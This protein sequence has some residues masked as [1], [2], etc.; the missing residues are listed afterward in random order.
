MMMYGAI[1]STVKEVILSRGDFDGV[2]PVGT[3]IQNLRTSVYGDTVT[4][5]GYHLSHDAGRYVAA[6]TWAGA[7]NGTNPKD[8]A[9]FPPK[10]EWTETQLAAIK[11]AAANALKKPYKITEASP[12][13]R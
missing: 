13:L 3:A 9:W 10:Y 4:R 1:L 2:I 11:E 6:L 5:D 8:V 7:L 12:E